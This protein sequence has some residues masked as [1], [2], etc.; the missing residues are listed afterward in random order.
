MKKTIGYAFI[1][2]VHFFCHRASAFGQ[3]IPETIDELLR[4]Y[5][6]QNAFNGTALVAQQGK[7]LIDKGY[8]Y[9]NLS[10]KTPNDS[11]TRFQVGSLTKQ[12]TA[13][14][15]LQLAEKHLIDLHDSVSKYLPDF[16][17]G[18]EIKIEN[19]LNHTSGIQD[20]VHDSL[21]QRRGW[22]NPISV[23]SLVYFF[24]S[25]PFHFVPGEGFEF[26]NSGYILLGMIIERVT[27]KPYYKVVRENIFQPLH[28][29]HSGFDFRS[30][31]PSLQ[32]LGYYGI[33]GTIADSSVLFA[34]GSMYSTAKDLYLWDQAL[35][36][37]KMLH[38]SSLAKA[39]TAYKS[40]YGF[41]WIIDSSNGKKAEMHEGVVLD[42][43]S[44]MVRVP[45]DGI[46]IILLD[47]HQSQA[48]VRIAED[49]NSILNNQ[50]YDWPIQRV[51]INLDPL[52]L[53]HYVGQY[54]LASDF[55]I[56]VTLEHGQL[57]AQA[58]GQEKVQL[59]AEKENLFFTKII[60]IQFE[61]LSNSEAKINRLILH[62]NGEP[63][64][65]IKIK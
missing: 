48:L 8:G 2:L 28:M 16:P 59:Y 50:P 63:Y 57:M 56:S 29:N 30:L 15:I 6:K 3:S 11:D 65:C 39:F 4:A 46:C 10:L 31:N 43:S 22:T 54:E 36:T 45:D 9:K 18:N 53:E 44:F 17:H 13:V 38:D 7:I 23:D 12:F 64:T 24:N 49:I 37:Q 55:F 47:N 41:G 34:S 5:A 25:K 20:Y 26:S 62:Q 40:K 21:F 58:T 19:L 52:I 35:Y 51:E 60:D 27:G 32:A 61:F 33:S 14:I 1:F 42:Y